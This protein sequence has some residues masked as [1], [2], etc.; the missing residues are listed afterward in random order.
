MTIAHTEAIP[1]EEVAQLRANFL[2]QLITPDDTAYD[3]AR[4]TWNGLIDRRPAVIARCIGNSDIVAALAFARERGLPLAVRGGGHSVAGYG[5]CDDGV[6]IDLSLM[7][8]VQVDPNVRRVRVQG[9]VTAADLD[10][11]TQLFGLATPSGNVS[12]TGVAGLTLSGGLSH[13]RRKYGMSVDNLVSADVITAD[14]AVQRVSADENSGLF[15]AIRGGGGNFGI[16]SSLEFRLHELGPLVSLAMVMYP[17]EMGREVL[18]FWCDFNESVPDEVS[19]DAIIWKVPPAPMFP[20]EIHGRS[21]VAIAAV[22]CGDTSEGERTLEPLRQ[23]GTPLFDMSR[24]IPWVALQ[25]AFDGPFPKGARYYWKSLYLDDMSD[26]TIDAILDRAV[27]RPSD[28]TFIPIRHLGGAI[29]RVPDTETAVG[30][31]GA[32]YLLSLDNA[33]VD[34]ADDEKNIAWVRSFWTAMQSHSHGGV[35]LNFAGTHEEGVAMAKAGHRANYDRLAALKSAYDPEN[36]F[37][38]NN[39]VLPAGRAS[40]PGAASQANPTERPA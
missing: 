17:L 10:R 28:M 24:P 8:G 39:N 14:G 20:A 21:I 7:R 11:E 1:A 29:S 9:G 37:R 22:H 36:V 6:V 38:Y 4:S 13:V 34:P 19:S 25:S 30:N 40:S 26:R 31:R 18:R 12:S 32:P 16:V 3:E 27:D 23:I 15:W 33:W 5:V 35:Y 2:G